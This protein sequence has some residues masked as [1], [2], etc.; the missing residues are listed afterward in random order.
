[1]KKI[2]VGFCDFWNGFD[3]EGFILTKALREHYEVEIKANPA[4]ADYVFYSLFGEEHWF[5]PDRCITIFYTG[6]NVCPDFNACDYAVG[7][8]WLDFADRYMRL[9][10][11]YCTRLFAEGTRQMELHPIPAD[12]EKRQFCSFVVS[13]ADANPIRQQFFEQLSAYRQ[14]DSGGRFMNNVGGPVA[15]KIAFHRQHKFVI[16]FENSSH[17]GYTTEKIFDAFAAGSIP[18]YWGDPEVCKVFNRK[19][20][21]E[22]TTIEEAL[23]QV[24]HLDQDDEAYLQM[25]T[26]PPLADDVFS[27]DNQFEAAVRFMTHIVEQPLPEAVRRNREFWGRKYADRERQLIAKSRKGLKEMILERIGFRHA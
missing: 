5:L 22:V 12:P 27:Y 25:L 26:Q 21:V 6:E 11:N 24:K 17:P 8:E 23:E 1:M 14:V 2:T 4:E 9:P 3:Q 20:F 10:N 13:N 7:F 19:A 15:D 16:A 18:I